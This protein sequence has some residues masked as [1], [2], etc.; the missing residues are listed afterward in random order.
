M[1]LWFLLF[2]VC[3]LVAGCEIYTFKTGVPTMASTRATSRKIVD[4]LIAEAAKRPSSETIK[5]L[6]LGSGN[7]R[8]VR[9]I[10]K[11]LPQAYVMGIELSPIPWARAVIQQKLFPLKNVV[12]ERKDF[13]SFDAS[14]FDAVVLYLSGNVFERMGRKL[15]N[16]LKLGAIVIGNE[17]FLPALGEPSE[18]HEAGFLKVKIT[19]YRR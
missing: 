13:W 5:V 2:V 19:V 16:E 4:I 11:A 18:T 3:L 12:Y 6:D 10:A 17:T 1:F 15:E 7:G 14:P 8:L 9:A